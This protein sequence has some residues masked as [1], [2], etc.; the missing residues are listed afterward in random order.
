MIKINEAAFRQYQFENTDHTME[1]EEEEEE[2]E[3]EKKRYINL[4]ITLLFTA[5]NVL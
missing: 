2:E 4:S 3:E 1:G 5:I